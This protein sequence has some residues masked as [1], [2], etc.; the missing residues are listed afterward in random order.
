MTVIDQIAIPRFDGAPACADDPA[1]F[2]PR[3]DVPAARAVCGRCPVRAQCLSFALA[4]DVHGV[5]AATTE[6]DRRELRTRSRLPAPPSVS[7]QL[8]D[9]VRSWRRVPP[10]P[11][12][13][14]DPDHICTTPLT[15]TPTV[16]NSGAP[17][18]ITA[19]AAAVAV[20]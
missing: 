3:P 2:L 6:D 10:N 20:A 11:D 14:D 12:Q 16:S 17:A 18:A 9:L 1:A 8:D 7:D 4:H 5:W 19:A 13:A 15:P